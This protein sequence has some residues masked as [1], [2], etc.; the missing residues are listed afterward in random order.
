MNRTVNPG[1]KTLSREKWEREQRAIAAAAHRAMIAANARM[2]A[3]SR[4]EMS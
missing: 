1:L 3:A 4:R 2:A